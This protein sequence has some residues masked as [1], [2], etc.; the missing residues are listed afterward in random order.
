MD[1]TQHRSFPLT[2]RS[3]AAPAKREIRQL[4]ITLGFSEKKLGELDLI[5]AE[6]TSNLVKYATNGELLM[7]SIPDKINPGIELISVDSGPGMVDPNR[8]LLDGVSTGGSLGQGLGAI[9][10]L[11]DLFQ[12]YSLPGRATVV[13]VRLFQQNVAAAGQ[14][15]LACVRWVIVP[16]PGERACGDGCFFN[17]TTTSL[18]V[19]LGDGLG[20]GP[21]ART[22]VRQAVRVLEGYR[23]KSPAVLIEAVHRAIRGTRGLVGTCAVFDFASRKWNVCGVGNITT[24]LSGSLGNRGYIAQNGIVGYN[25]PSGLIDVEMSYERGQCL[26]MASDGLQSRWNPARYAGIGKYDPSVLAALLYKEYTRY[27]D[28]ASVV[29][30]KIY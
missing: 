9:K 6:L 4:A 26:V 12:L 24:Q 2:D 22:A 14:L 15:P 18:R 30:A 21:L 20:H 3:Y 19:F 29:V 17:L 23:D 5:V 13:L 25:V 8:M 16:K 7:R 11:A 28:D 1:D 27:S 10:R